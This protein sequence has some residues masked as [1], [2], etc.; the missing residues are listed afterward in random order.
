MREPLNIRVLVVGCGAVGG[1]ISTGLLEQGYDLTVVTPN[2]AIRDAVRENGFVAL[3]GAERRR[4]PSDP[5][6]VTDALSPDTAPFDFIILATQPPQVEEAARSSLP[7]LA[8]QGRMVC[9]QNG[10]C[11]ERVAAIVGADRVVGAIV[12]WG[13]SMPAPGIFERTSA[14]G[15]TIGRLDG[16]RDHALDELGWMLECVGPVEITDNLRG[17]RWSKLAI[18]CAISTLGT[19][20]GDRLG[21]L[22]RK[23]FVRRLAL[24]IMTETVEVAR[25]DGVR[26]EKVAG[27]L[28]LEW[29][30]LTRREKLLAGSAGLVAK[31][32][33]LLA[34]GTRYRK[35]RSSMLAAIE[36]GRAPAVNFL[37]GEV[38]DR[39]GP[40]RI[41]AHVNARAKELVWAISRGDVTPSHRLL[42]R[43]YRETRPGMSQARA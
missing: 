27:T 38:V 24:D 32:T 28:D 36:R 2:L 23:R 10:L 14:G 31:H 30:A 35:L 5:D 39:A 6:K 26:L 20:G 16:G 15:F 22:L 34:V 43:L 9:I 17:A 37:N 8:S 4:L 21:V 42:R 13:A 33:L 41:E 29:L 19:I 40:S 7:F 25:T 11:E 18:N 1:T 3:E 12:A